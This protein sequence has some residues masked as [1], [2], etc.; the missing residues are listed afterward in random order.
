MID[1]QEFRE[2]LASYALGALEE[3]ER[4]A[5]E[6]HLDACADCR[7]ELREQTQVLVRL[8]E[9]LPEAS[10]RPALR[11]TVL[12][13]ARAARSP[14]VRA[15]DSSAEQSVRVQK[16]VDDRLSRAHTGP[17]DSSL[18]A[19][20]WLAAAAMAGLAILSGWAYLTA[21]RDY[22]AAALRADR[23]VAELEAERT[24]AAVAEDLVETLLS[25]DV[26]TAS[27]AT[28][29]EAPSIRLFWNRDRNVVVVAAFDL[30]APP[31]GR[32]YQLWGI[33][34]AAGTAPVGL[35]TFAPG[36]EGRTIATFQIP[37]ELQ[38]DLAAVTEEPDGGSPAPTTAPFLAGPIPASD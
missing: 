31:A 6:K 33:D 22:E 5:L 27:L 19:A 8:A 1:H 23:L 2:Q 7:R 20:G 26:A 24:R 3:P 10:P 14:R 28:T 15:I 38:F 36:G 17:P 18:G 30:P 12:R 25:Q 32:T 11:A 16:D 4:T 37:A 9:G 21:D 29:A 13:R 35:G 34:T